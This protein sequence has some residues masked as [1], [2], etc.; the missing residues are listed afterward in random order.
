MLGTD[1][2]AADVVSEAAL[3][4]ISLSLWGRLR[5]AAEWEALQAATFNEDEFQTFMWVL[6]EGPENLIGW[7]PTLHGKQPSTSV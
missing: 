4:S 2:H 3:C 7:G 6:V 5:I 1:V